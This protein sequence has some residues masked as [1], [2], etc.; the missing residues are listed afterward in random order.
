MDFTIDL[1]GVATPAELHRRVRAALPCPA[2]YGDNLDAL[3]DLLTDQG[4]GW[5]IT[6]LRT[7]E[8]DTMLPAYT[9]S[10]RRL[11]ARAM[12]ETPGLQIGFEE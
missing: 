12:A 7:A 8:T 10:L 9:A 6:F 2:W 5:R 1:A 4:S 11:C 3:Y